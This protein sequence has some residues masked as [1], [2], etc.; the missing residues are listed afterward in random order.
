LQGFVLAAGENRG[1]FFLGVLCGVFF[2]LDGFVNFFSMDLYALWGGY[3]QADF[4]APDVDDE[5]LDVIAYH[6]RF[7]FLSAQNQHFSIPFAGWYNPVFL[8]KEPA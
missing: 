8:R 1:L 4:V 6:N 5:D 7:I 3:A 2:P